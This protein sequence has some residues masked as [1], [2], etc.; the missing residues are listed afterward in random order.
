M[1]HTKKLVIAILAQESLFTGQLCAKPSV[2]APGSQFAN[3]A[4]TFQEECERKWGGGKYLPRPSC[5]YL[6][7]PP[8]L[9]RGNSPFDEIELQ[10]GKEIGHF[11][12]AHAACL[13][14]W[15]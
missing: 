11:N 13:A 14:A 3:V 9:G 5:K 7:I 4:F 8:R 1:A 10:C 2:M 12:Y 6:F 15:S